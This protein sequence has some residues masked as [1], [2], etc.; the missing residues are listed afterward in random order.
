MSRCHGGNIFVWQ[1]T[2]ILFKSKFALFQS[3]SN[4]FSFIWFVKCWWN[5]LDLIRKDGIL[6]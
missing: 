1:Q 5:F 6:V 4:L 3:S 2:K